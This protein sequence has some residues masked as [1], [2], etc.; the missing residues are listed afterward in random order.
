M[1]SPEA[2]WI[3]PA[4]VAG[5]AYRY[6]HSQIRHRYQL[7]SQCEPVALF[8]D[9]LGFRAVPRERIVDWTLFFDTYGAPP[10]QRSKKIDGKL[11]RALIDLPLAITGEC[12]FDAYHSLAERDLQRGHGVGLPSGE[13][14]ARH[15]GV[16]PLTAAEIGITANG[17]Q[18]ETPLWCYI[19][20]WPT[21]GPAAIVWDQSAA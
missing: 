9:L 8:P 6:D 3:Y 4:R 11:V 7:H 14:V 21:S 1:V 12:E 19:L 17:N 15:I 13:A 18:G 5:A 2:W 20:R 10:A 16:E